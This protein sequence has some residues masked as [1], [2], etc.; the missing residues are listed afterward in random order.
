MHMLL[1][2]LSLGLIYTKLKR[3]TSSTNVNILLQ[4]CTCLTSTAEH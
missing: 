3:N 2:R 1:D 4:G